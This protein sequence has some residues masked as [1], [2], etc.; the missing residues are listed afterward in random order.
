M[1]LT[2]SKKRIALL[3]GAIVLALAIW[4]GL[5][6][7]MP[8]AQ[9]YFDPVGTRHLQTDEIGQLKSVSEEYLNLSLSGDDFKGWNTENQGFW[10]YVIA[11][12]FYGL[13]SAM[14]IDPAHAAEYKAT[15]DQMIGKMKSKKVWGDFTDHGFGTDPISVQNIMYKGHLNLMFGLFQ[16]STGD[17]R[18]AREFAWLTKQ[19][20]EEMRLHHRGYYEGV[21]CEPNAW[22]VECNTIGIMSLHIY[23]KLYGTH[24]ALNEIQW[25]LD[26][27]KSRMQDKDSG[28]YYRVYMPNLDT[29]NKQLLGYTNAWVLTFLHP[30][31]KDEIEN[32]YPVF[33]E[34]LTYSIG[35]YAAIRRQTGSKPDK[36]AQ[37]F[38]MW[39]AKELGDPV[40]FGKLRNAVDKFGRLSPEESS[41]GLGYED[42]D[43]RLING[44][45]LATK[46]HLGWN[47][48]I[49]HDWGHRKLPYAEPNIAGMDW[50]DLLPDR[51]YAMNRGGAL[52][53]AIDKRPCPNCFW[54]DYRSVPML[55]KGK[56]AE[57]SI[58]PPNTGSSCGLTSL[59]PLE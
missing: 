29:V 21:T 50:R 48:V 9:R 32:T 40:L 53:D 11:F 7:E 10:K 24:Y 36:V 54:G 37:I 12:S 42:A 49:D 22:F 52:P 3:T 30:F 33:K 25:S 38:G 43:G 17:L 57:Q 28:L 13:P 14:I 44:V 41:G 35:P 19:L 45:V 6:W 20:A 55:S 27:I 16:L 46:L 5:P 34:R 2:L 18:Y 59:A 58:C 4:L 26:F 51:I 31:L 15:M 8:D 23:D 56:K 47:N 39:A 1:M